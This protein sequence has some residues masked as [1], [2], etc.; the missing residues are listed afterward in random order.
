MPSWASSGTRDWGPWLEEVSMPRAIWRGSIAFGLVNLPVEAH[1][2]V[3]DHRPH[4][5]L[6]CADGRSR[7]K[8]ERV[9]QR[10]GRSVSWNELVKGYEYEKGKFVVLTRKD[11]EAAALERSDIIDIIDFVQAEEVDG[12]YFERP[13]YLLPSRGGE[14][15][16]DLLRAALRESEEI[17][18]GKMIL[19]QVQPRE[20][21]VFQTGS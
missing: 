8:Y 5:K 11:F 13:Y 17:G 10:N 4:F 19:R 15:T 18:I 20:G 16:Y 3:H 1:K 14:S 7:V 9:C 12:R 2:A 21:D 6:L